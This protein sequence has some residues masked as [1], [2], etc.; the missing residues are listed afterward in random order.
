[1]LVECKE[2]EVMLSEN[3]LQ[4][5]LRYNI[6]VPVEFMVLTNGHSTIGWKKQD[7]ALTLLEALPAFE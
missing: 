7:G 2:P 4:Q 3:V 6:S 1:M 5:V